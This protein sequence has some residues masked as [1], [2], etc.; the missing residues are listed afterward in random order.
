MYII[1]HLNLTPMNF[2]VK[3]SM[4]KVTGQVCLENC[5]RKITCILINN[6]FLNFTYIYRLTKT[7]IHFGFEKVNGQGQGQRSGF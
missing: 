5:L 2:G 1:R 3:I 7:Y 6:L 4:V